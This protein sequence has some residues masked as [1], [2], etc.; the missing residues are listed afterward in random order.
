MALY[1]YKCDECDLTE[2]VWG[3]MSDPIPAAPVCPNCGKPMKRI[4]GS[5]AVHIPPHMKA[6]DDSVSVTE[7]GNRLNRSRPSGKRKTFY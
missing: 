5:A 7:I 4:W 3:N 6:G 2:A 1:E